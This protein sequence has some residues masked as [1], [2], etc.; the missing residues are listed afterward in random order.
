MD[1]FINILFFFIQVSKLVLEQFKAKAREL[2]FGDEKEIYIYL[3]EW[4]W[5]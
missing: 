2:I 3:N 5:M 1:H 4:R